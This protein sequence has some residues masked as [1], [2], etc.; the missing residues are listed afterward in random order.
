MTVKKT[1]YIV[2]YLAIIVGAAYK[3][4]KKVTVKEPPRKNPQKPLCGLQQSLEVNGRA[5]CMAGLRTDIRLNDIWASQMERRIRNDVKKRICNDFAMPKMPSEDIPAAIER[6]LES[7][8][9]RKR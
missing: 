5:D 6:A 9:E 4:F 3:I 2:T 8:F 7:H 1:L